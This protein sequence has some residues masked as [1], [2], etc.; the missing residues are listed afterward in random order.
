M[1]SIL[2]NTLLALLLMSRE[3][4]GLRPLNLANDQATQSASHIKPGRC[5]YKP[6]EL[7]SRVKDSLKPEKLDG[8]W[9]VIYDGKEM[10][11]NFTCQT[12]KLS[13]P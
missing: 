11:Q 1:P 8:V 2:H 6:G 10:N 3:V 12:L 7:K 9:R 13:T 5:P 4:S